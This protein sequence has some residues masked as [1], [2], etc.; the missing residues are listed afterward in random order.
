MARGKSNRDP[1]KGLENR[2]NGIFKKSNTFYRIYG[3]QIAVIVRYQDRVE[4][5][6]SQPGLL[7]SQGCTSVPTDCIKGPDDFDLVRDRAGA[8]APTAQ[9][10]APVAAMETVESLGDVFSPPL[11][12]SSSSDARTET[13]TNLAQEEASDMFTAMDILSRTPP[14]SDSSIFQDSSPARVP[15]EIDGIPLPSMLLP[16]ANQ[17]NSA[18]DADLTRS[19]DIHCPRPISIRRKQ[20]LL[21]LAGQFFE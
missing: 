17:H 12:S 11:L 20:A 10:N 21:S 1:R 6:E 13:P 14:M 16:S 9:A 19:I 5:Y 3:A 7:S 18:N 4:A 15:S 2:R 8:D